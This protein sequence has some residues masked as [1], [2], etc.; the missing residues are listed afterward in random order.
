MV[1]LDLGV[2]SAHSAV[3]LDVTGQVLARR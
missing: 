3:V 2:T 1:G